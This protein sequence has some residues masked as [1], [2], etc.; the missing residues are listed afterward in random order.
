VKRPADIVAR[1]GGEEFVV[2][3]PS[4]D[5]QGA[6]FIAEAFRK[7]LRGLALPHEAGPTGLVTA[8]V[9]LCV[10]TGRGERDIDLLARADKALYEAKAAGRDR[11]TAWH[12]I[13]EQDAS[14]RA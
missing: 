1:Y 9:G 12:P 3:L 14:R 2:L 8:S 13:L 7:A 4:T 10:S 11:V 5:E 6:F